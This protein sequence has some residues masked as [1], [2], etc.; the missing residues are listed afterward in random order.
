MGGGEGSQTAFWRTAWPLSS[1]SQSRGGRERGSSWLGNSEGAAE[2]QGDGADRGK[3][4]LVCVEG[5]D[6]VLAGLVDA[7]K[8][9][10]RGLLS[11]LEVRLGFCFH[12]FGGSERRGGAANLFLEELEFLDVDV[13]LG[14]E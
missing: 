4:L 5:G 11:P 13:R 12:V 8:R 7:L 2:R 9:R 1:A 14:A 10:L 6:V 3:R